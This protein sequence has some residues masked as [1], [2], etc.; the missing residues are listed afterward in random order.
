MAADYNIEHWTSA[1]I[2]LEGGK[3]NAISIPVNDRAATRQAIITTLARKGHKLIERSSWHAEAPRAAM[4]ESHW[5]YQ[6]IVIHHA[7]R[8]YSCGAPSMTEIQRAQRDDMRRSIPFDDIGYHYAISC[9]GV[10]YEGRDIRYVGEHVSGGNTG[11]VGIVLLADLV[12]AGEAYEQEYKDMSLG[13]RIKAL[14]QILVDRL[15]INHDKPTEPQ[16]KALGTLSEVLKEFF[17]ITRLG[18]HREYQMLTNGNGRACPG[19]LGMTIVKSMRSQLG[20]SAP[21][22]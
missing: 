4:R 6:D 18:G 11:K 10:I 17:N 9:Q 13:Q 20:L 19:D 15:V 1:P 22:K 8:S 14:P 5:D 16:V 3:N 7:G 2:V 21:N 12:K